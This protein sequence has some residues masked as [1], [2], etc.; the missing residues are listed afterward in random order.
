MSEICTDCRKILKNPTFKTPPHEKLS[1][2]KER[3]IK[4]IGQ[5][6]YI[7]IKYKCS[8]CHSILLNE[9]DKNDAVYWFL[10]N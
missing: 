9:N 2:I 6:S 8:T 5:P 4:H 7:S 3:N 1:I 10:L